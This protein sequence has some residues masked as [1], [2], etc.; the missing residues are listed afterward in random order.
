QRRQSA[1][2][3]ALRADPDVRG[4]VSAIG[5]GTVN[6]TTNV[7]RIVITLRPRGERE[8][9]LA[10]VIERLK[11]RV[12]SVAGMA[13]YCQP[14]QDIQ[15]GTRASRAQYQYT[16]TGTDSEEVTTWTKRLVAELR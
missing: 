16:L 10:A 15:I 8:S 12:A 13:S 1:V 4:V 11:G 7:G 3:E 6:P 14:V 9:D 2:A 5:A